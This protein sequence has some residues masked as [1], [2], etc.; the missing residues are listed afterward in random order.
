MVSR[1]TTPSK[2][3]KSTPR[4]YP[5]AAIVG[6]EEMK[7]ALLLN[8]IDSHIGG[9]LIMGHR[10][11]G[12]S[13]AVRGLAELLP[14]IAVV[15]GCLYRCDPADV[16]NLCADCH[17]THAKE[18]RL[19]KT[20]VAV[21]LVELPLGATEDRVCGSIDFQRALSEGTKSFEPGLLARANRGFLYIDEVNLLD[22]HLVDL[23]LDVAVTGR[24]KVERE[25][26]SVE[27]P[28]A[29]VLIGSGNPEEGELRPQLLDRF[30][31][32][33]EILTETDLDQRMEIVERQSS[34]ESDP[35]AFLKRFGSDQ[36][37]LRQRIT[38]ARKTLPSVKIDRELLRRI[39]ELST[40]LKLDG[41]RGEL[42]MARAARAVAAFEN[43]RKVVE[44][45]VRR[46]AP[47]AVR[48]RLRSD[49]FDEIGSA[50]RINR[51]LDK[52]FDK[53]PVQQHS[54]G[55]DY[56][57]NGKPSGHEPQ[58][59]D[60]SAKTYKATIESSANG[61]GGRVEERPQFS[62]GKQ[63]GVL[64]RF[65]ELQTQKK[66]KSKTAS[67]SRRKVPASS[68]RNSN[69]GRYAYAVAAPQSLRIAVDATLRA[70]SSYG[71]PLTP[72]VL[73]EALRYKQFS[74][75]RGALYV[76]AID[77]S[78]SM[79][80]QRINRAREV[81]VALLRKAY[82]NRDNVA[83]VAFRGENAEVVLCPS[84]SMLRAK[85]A[86]ESLAVGGATPLSAGL[87]RA[88]KLAKSAQPR[89]G[90]ATVL[91]FTDGNANVPLLSVG[92]DRQLRKTQ[93]R[94][95]LNELSRQFRNAG[96]G[97]F[98]IDPQHGFNTS[99]K[100]RSVATRLNA[101]LVSCQ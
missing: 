57:G 62:N 35:E 99:T 85:R 66:R 76:L 82:I 70:L 45:D 49:P 54:D 100:A 44:S 84:R 34:F 80:Q 75:K 95:E 10:G 38:R 11:T 15:T 31:L 68:A 30:G 16:A 33:V 81:A 25:S 22:D 83:I 78:G 32:H 39:A 88:F 5:F 74:Q 17:A 1:S 97:L 86:V 64:E 51:A 36:D 24:N 67:N 56:D 58:T 28:S 26:I 98:V 79:A 73:N 4:H 69:R 47:M 96:I 59:R 20:H 61:M 41:H 18:Q 93:I 94:Y 42:T 8:A 13:T 72:Q 27:H 52:V 48:H 6:Q 90:E 2:S 101:H 14:A 65:D 53:K 71:L 40:E 23:L 37:Q 3:N 89:H 63:D 43:R 91:L 87:L 60:E 12:K 19:S 77:T 9:V 92:T 50:E 46:V 21:N 29:F 7:L 55:G